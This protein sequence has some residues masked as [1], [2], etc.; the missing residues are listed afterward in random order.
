MLSHVVFL[1]LTL[2]VSL[3][4][5]AEA[6]FTRE[7]RISVYGQVE[8]GRC[9]GLIAVLSARGELDNRTDIGSNGDFQ[10]PD[11]PA[12]M[13]ELTVTT[14]N[15]D[16]IYRQQVS[17]SSMMNRI[18]VRL[19]A[20]NEEQPGA[21]TVSARQLLYKVPSKALKEFDKGMAAK[22]KN[23]SQAAMEHLIK[24][25]ELDPDFMEAHNNLGLQYLQT[26]NI[27]EAV[28]QFQRAAELDPDAVSPEINLA[29]TLVLLNRS[30]DAE[31]AAR[32]AVRLDAASPTAHY[33]LGVAL[34]DQQKITDEAL[35]NLE[36]ASRT[37]PRARLAIDEL[38]ERRG[39]VERARKKLLT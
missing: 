1:S 30:G 6:Q 39:E 11:L 13:Y 5:R 2:L 17:L 27:S 18:S 33:L 36:E 32:H 3:A 24:A 21:G 29:A 20:Q 34:L 14:L 28:A 15:G 4:P 23:D 31:T 35:G 25:A 16:V 12:G 8:S 10:F 9:D 26:G 38:V 19:P 37:I 22:K 7:N